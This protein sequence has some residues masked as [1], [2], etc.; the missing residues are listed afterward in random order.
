MTYFDALNAC[1]LSES[2]LN[3]VYEYIDQLTEADELDCLRYPSYMEKLLEIL[4]KPDA[5][6]VC[7]VYGDYTTQWLDRVYVYK[8]DRRISLRLGYHNEYTFMKR[9]VGI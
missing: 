4:I 3:E 9:L 5:I 1:N 6:M 7:S 8:N 2:T